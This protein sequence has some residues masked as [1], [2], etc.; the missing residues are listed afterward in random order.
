MNIFVPVHSHKQLESYSLSNV[1]AVIFSTVFCSTKTQHPSTVSELEILSKKANQL[2]LPWY[3]SINRMIL[4]SEWS[5]LLSEI[6]QINEYLP[7]G[8]IVSDL[9]V[10]HYLK[11]N[12]PLKTIVLQTDTT[13][14]NAYDVEVL[15][16]MGADIVALAKELTLSEVTQIVQRFGSRVL[17]SGFGHQC[18][19]TSN[20][21][22]MSNY[23]NHIQKD[24]EV[25]YKRFTLQEE[26]R[27]EGYYAIQDTHGF[28]IFTSSVL[29]IFDEVEKLAENGLGH[30]MI[31]S[32]FVDDDTILK[33]IQA[34]KKEIDIEYA[35][36]E[37]SKRYSLS[38]ALYYTA[39]SAIKVVSE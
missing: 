35:K 5:D 13:I 7:T 22:L 25:M 1:D 33:V 20:R 14:T 11:K 21:P 17:I 23:F 8:Y 3:L 9:G 31:D 16:S 2:H 32:L 18:M 15:L 10:L 19:S 26:G 28:H 37:I 12:Y 29:E 39:T 6:L 27:T 30:L 34:F 38:K 24:V 4:Q 36:S